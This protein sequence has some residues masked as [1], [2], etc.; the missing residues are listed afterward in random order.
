M[1]CLAT[2]LRF[3]TELHAD[4]SPAV[5]PPRHAL[6]HEVVRFV[7]EAVVAVVA[8]T[9]EAARA[10]AEAV[11]VDYEELPCVTD[12]VRATSSGAPALCT[13][14]PDNIAAEM[15]HGDAPA[16][17]LAFDR[18][19]HRIAL[20]LVNQRLAPSP[21]E[22]RST[23]AYRDSRTGRLTVRMA[24]QM[25]ATAM[26]VFESTLPNL[27]SG[28]VRVLVGDIGGGFGMKGSAYPEDV[29][30]AHAALALGRPVKWTADRIEDFLAGNAGRDTTSQAELALDKDGKILA[31]RVCS[32]SNV[33]AYATGIGVA[34]ALLV[35]PWVSTSVYDIPTIDLHLKA[36][37]TNTAQVGAYRGAGRPEAIYII[38]RLLDAAARKMNLD[39][40][41]LRR[42]NLVRPD[43]MPYTNAMKQTYDSGQF[44]RMLDQGLAL[45]EWG[46]FDARREASGARGRLRGRGIATF[47][48][49]TGGSAFTERVTI[50]VT[51]DGIIEISSGTQAMGQGIATSYAQ[52]AVDVFE[53]SIDRIR[54][55]QGDTDRVRGFGSAGSRSLFTGGSAV[56][57]A[58]Q[59]TVEQ[60]KDLAADALEVSASDITYRAGRFTV[61]GT[62]VAIDLFELASRQPEAKIFVDASHTVEGESWPNACHVCEVEIDPATGAVEVVAYASVNDIGRVVSP[63][64]VRGRTAR[65]ARQ[66]DS[67]TPMPSM[68]KVDGR[69]SRAMRRTEGKNCPSC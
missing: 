68:W 46:S 50:S 67:K 44:E 20:D 29:L 63:D 58:S 26:Q 34:I 37:L 57:V 62:D 56:C 52:L 27:P 69:L 5:S 31:L 4:G 39:P 43:Q 65:W 10:A 64:I 40:A 19:A 14:A 32:L 28:G 61:T 25:P 45:S 60:A 53:V 42:R 9:R 35:G 8:E 33:G 22:P 47:L 2:F 12:P 13:A 11:W 51:P 16:A 59:R 30:V 48:E 21:I 17:S 7:G 1:T 66:V 24:S 6:A 49:W 54:I 38:E 15:R 23:L 18:A 41:E 55:V 3:A 36:V